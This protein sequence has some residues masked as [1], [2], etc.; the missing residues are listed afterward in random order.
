MNTTWQKDTES[1]EFSSLKHTVTTDVVVIGGGMTGTIVAYELAK[2]GKRVVVIEKGTLRKT[3]V[4]AYTTAFLSTDIDTDLPDLVHIFSRKQA[5]EIWQSHSHAIDMVEKNIKD[6]KISCDFKRIPEHWIATSKRGFVRLQKEARLA[7][8]FG[9]LVEEV[10]KNSFAFDNEGAFVFADQ[11]KFHPLKYVLEI[12]KA[13]VELGVMF[14]EHTKA[15][16]MHGDET[17][18]VET[19]YGTVE[20]KDAVMATY[21]PF[22]NPS[23]L[24]AKKGMYVSYIYEL[25]IAKNILPEGIYL[26][27]QNPYHYFRVDR[28]E[29][30]DRVILGGEDHRE[31]LPIDED[32]N[33]AALKKYFRQRFPNVPYTVV[34]R[35]SGPILESIDGLAFIGRYDSQY[36][37]RYVATAF[38]GNGMT[39]AHIAAE[40]ITGLIT[41]QPSP[42]T[43]LYNPFRPHITMM[44]LLIK[45]RDYVGEIFGGYVKNLFRK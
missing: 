26:D 6:L 24:F 44:G 21:M 2:A 41:K 13:A 22:I 28:G 8:H 12:R 18:V 9:F 11:A 29:E 36:P 20:A 37:N 5:K 3:S 35:W 39:Y 38:S 42:Y 15:I 32:T 7:K 1:K 43:H 31:E 10:P 30:Q 45:T 23:L 25:A 40:I 16:S 14:Y 27:D 19:R 34:G 4:T 33:F 17:V